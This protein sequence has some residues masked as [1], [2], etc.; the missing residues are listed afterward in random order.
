MATLRLLSS[1]RESG[2]QIGNESSRGSTQ[3][4]GKHRPLCLNWASRLKT[5]IELAEDL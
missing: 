5:P 1:S 3:R 2:Y 4:S